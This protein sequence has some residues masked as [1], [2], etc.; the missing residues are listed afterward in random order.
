MSKSWYNFDTDIQCVEDCFSIAEI[1]IVYKNE[2]MSV[3]CS[4]SIW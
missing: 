4:K 1:E 3:S 2:R